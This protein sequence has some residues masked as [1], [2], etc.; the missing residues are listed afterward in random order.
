MRELI[1]WRVITKETD[2]L[3]VWFSFLTKPKSIQSDHGSH[4][5]ARIIQE[6]EKEE[7]IQWVI[8]TP[9]HLQA[10]G[11]V[12]RANGLPEQFLRPQDPEWPD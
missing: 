7:G 10:N 1:V 3:K 9:Y 11:I 2:G 8:H 5:T 6:W 4:F 12:E